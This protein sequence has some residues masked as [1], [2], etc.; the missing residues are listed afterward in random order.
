MNAE[1]APEPTVR[2]IRD[3]Y[4]DAILAALEVFDGDKKRAAKALGISFKTLYNKLHRYGLAGEWV[5]PRGG[6]RRR[7][8]PSSVIVEAHGFEVAPPTV[9]RLA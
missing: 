5:G 7:V 1:R 3:L 6:S 8:Q 4:K 2:P 9:G